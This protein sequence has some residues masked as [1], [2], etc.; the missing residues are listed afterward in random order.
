MYKRTHIRIQTIRSLARGINTTIASLVLKFLLWHSLKIIVCNHS[1]STFHFFVL[2]FFLWI[3]MSIWENEENSSL[4]LQNETEQE[5]KKK[6]FVWIFFV[7][8]KAYDGSER[9]DKCN[10]LYGLFWLDK[11]IL[12][13]F[14]NWDLLLIIRNC[15]RREMSAKYRFSLQT[16]E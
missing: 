5:I 4:Q 8:V 6:H 3:Y 7:T 11:R 2:S 13:N 16:N 10:F 15:T 14:G 9:L 1:V 12:S